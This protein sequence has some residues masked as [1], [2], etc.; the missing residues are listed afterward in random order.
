MASGTSSSV[1]G[2]QDSGRFA[3]DTTTIRLSSSGR[4]ENEKDGFLQGEVGLDLAL[5]SDAADTRSLRIRLGAGLPIDSNMV[6]LF[7]FQ[8]STLILT[9]ASEIDFIYNLDFGLRYQKG[10]IEA[11]VMSLLPVGGRF[12]VGYRF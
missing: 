8:M 5:K 1:L 11:G 12:E 3:V 6:V 4:I 9:E 2:A 7:E 10:R